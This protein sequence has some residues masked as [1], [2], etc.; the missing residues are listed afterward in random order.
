MDSNSMLH[1][2]WNLITLHGDDVGKDV[3]D[4]VFGDHIA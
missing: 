3:P 1:L 2:D 4:I